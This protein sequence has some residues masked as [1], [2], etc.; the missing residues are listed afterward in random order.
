[1]KTSSV[2]DPKN[3]GRPSLN[4]NTLLR[5]P[6]EVQ[7]SESGHALECTVEGKEMCRLQKQCWKAIHKMQCWA[8][9]KL[10]SCM[11]SINV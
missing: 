11:A 2:S 3:S 9:C 1:M 8:A 6:E 5:V 7:S 10:F 4:K